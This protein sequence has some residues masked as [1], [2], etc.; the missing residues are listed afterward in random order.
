MIDSSPNRKIVLI[1]PSLRHGGAERV[2]TILAN[3][4]AKD[5]E[6][7]ITLLILTKQIQYYKLDDRVTIIEPSR[8]YNNNSISKFLY[9]L[10]SLKF[11]R[12]EISKI[13]PDAILSFCE[14]YNNLVLLSLIGL[15][16]KIFVSDRNNPG[17]N[18]GFFHENL[19]KLLYKNA[20]GIIAQTKN[21]KEILY[22]KTKN[23][24][25]VN[26]PNP[27]R[28]I[29]DLNTIKEKIILNVGRNEDQKNQLQLIEMFFELHNAVDWKLYILGN[30]ELRDQLDRK[31]LDLGLKSRVVLMDFQSDIDSYFQKSS[32][33]AFPSLYEGFPNAL[34][35]AMANGIP[36][37]VYDCPTGP[38][39]MIENNINGFLVPLQDKRTFT[40]QL[41]LLV[42]NEL[43]RKKIGVEAAKIKE[44]LAVDK[45]CD[46][47]LH[48]ILEI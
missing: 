40:I 24:N 35:E 4:W 29:D 3:Q 9:R 30:G 39:E 21:G 28:A 8:T 1:I 26:I 10:W 45:I 27:L 14:I 31:V 34:S 20:S 46:E 47:Y 22:R 37:V 13:K 42:D 33:F 2:I 43:L 48:T 19:R 6:I 41:Q 25:I 23:K 18:L 12:A 17:N 7:N 11:I 16:F 44:K 32:I 36:C 15:N 38:G 5:P